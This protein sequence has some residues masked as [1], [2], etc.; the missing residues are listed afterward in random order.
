PHT[1]HTMNRVPFILITPDG[2]K[3]PLREGDLC[4]VSPTILHLMGLPKP[5]E[6]TAE[7]LI[8]VEMPSGA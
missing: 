7:S 2:S 5:P 3:P 1:A 8:A 4:N 6:M